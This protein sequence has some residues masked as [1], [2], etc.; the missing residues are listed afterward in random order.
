[1]A[2]LKKWCFGDLF[3]WGKFYPKILCKLEGKVI[4]TNKSCKFF[5]PE[6]LSKKI[7]SKDLRNFFKPLFTGLI[8]N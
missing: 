5:Y 2:K 8:Q 6:E 3:E 7:L 1:M 4:H